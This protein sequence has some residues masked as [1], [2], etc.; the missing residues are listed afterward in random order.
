MGYFAYRY[1]PI[2]FLELLAE[3]KIRLRDRQTTSIEILFK[4]QNFSSTFFCC[5]HSHSMGHLT[6]QGMVISAC[7]DVFFLMYSP[8][9]SLSLSREY[10]YISFCIHSSYEN[11]VYESFRAIKFNV[12]FFIYF[13]NSRLWKFLKKSKCSTPML[14][15]KLWKTVTQQPKLTENDNISFKHLRKSTAL[16]NSLKS[17]MANQLK[18]ASLSSLVQADEGL[19]RP[20]CQTNVDIDQCALS[21]LFWYF[22]NTTPI[23]SLHLSLLKSF[24]PI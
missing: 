14:W 19:Y 15:W 7:I 18:P 24:I 11:L 22:K 12:S 20:S 8:H 4:V 1:V 2:K 6:L 5:H 9:L 13:E 21:I 10:T 16:V 3:C 17:I 23:T